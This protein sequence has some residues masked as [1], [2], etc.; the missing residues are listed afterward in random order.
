[1]V[2]ELATGGSIAAAI[3]V[4]QDFY[5][6]KTGVYAKTSTSY[7]GGHAVRLIGY[8][9]ENGVKYWLAANS[10]GANWGLSGFFKIKRG[11]N[12]CKIKA[13]TRMP[14]SLFN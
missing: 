3:D 10:W 9:V 6:Y 12:E 1:M 7:L 11:S 4:Y 14:L 5:T 2:S 8:G 13:T